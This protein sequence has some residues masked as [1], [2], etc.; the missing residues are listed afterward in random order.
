V[1]TEILEAAVVLYK[2]Y[3]VNPPVFSLCVKSNG[4][5]ISDEMTRVKDGTFY[6]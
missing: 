5:V 2:D 3:P 6:C 4:K 1:S